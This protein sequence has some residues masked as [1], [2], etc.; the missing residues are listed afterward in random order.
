MEKNYSL[1]F[2][3][4]LWFPDSDVQ[5]HKR[6]LKDRLNSPKTVDQ[7]RLNQRYILNNEKEL[8]SR[9]TSFDKKNKLL[10]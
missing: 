6:K 10:I 1:F 7:T 2:Y 5:K 9:F 4:T 3:R 8:K